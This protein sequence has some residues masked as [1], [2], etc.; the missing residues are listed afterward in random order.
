MTTAT[1]SSVRH[2]QLICV[3]LGFLLALV[4]AASGQ[5]GAVDPESGKRAAGWRCEFRNT[6]AREPL[7]IEARVYCVGR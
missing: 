4:Q 2:P 5:A 6:S 7:T 1:N 3:S